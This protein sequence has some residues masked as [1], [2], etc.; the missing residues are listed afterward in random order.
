MRVADNA[1][2]DDFL[3]VAGDDFAAREPAFDRWWSSFAEPA[4][5]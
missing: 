5:G 4:P 2:T 3:L 1:C